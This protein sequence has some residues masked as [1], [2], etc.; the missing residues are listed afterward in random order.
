M[1][2][3]DGKKLAKHIRKEIRTKIENKYLKEQ[4]EN[5]KFKS[6]RLPS[7]VRHNHKNQTIQRLNLSVKTSPENFV[8]EDFIKNLQLA[9][10]E[11][12]ALILQDLTGKRFIYPNEYEELKPIYDFI[13]EGGDRISY[14]RKVR[15]T[16]EELFDIIEN[17]EIF[18]MDKFENFEKYSNEIF[19]NKNIPQEEFNEVLKF[20]ND[21]AIPKIKSCSNSVEHPVFHKNAVMHEI[22][23]YTSYNKLMENL[24]YIKENY[25]ITTTEKTL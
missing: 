7:N 14:F 10:C 18:T 13:K 2:S 9:S 23:D 8:K 5:E 11:V 20:Y 3:I 17:Y 4:Y 21:I 1:R 25:V 6:D 15:L 12:F 24:S 19:E 22:N 16:N